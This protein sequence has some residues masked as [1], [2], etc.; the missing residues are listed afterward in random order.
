MTWD[1]VAHAI[2]VMFLVAG[3]AGAPLEPGRIALSGACALG[4]GF[5]LRNRHAFMKATAL[6]A[7]IG[8]ASYFQHSTLPALWR[9]LAMCAF[10]IIAF[11]PANR[12]RVDA[13]LA[14]AAVAGSLLLFFA[15][16]D[17]I[18]RNNW[19]VRLVPQLA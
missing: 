18:R 19:R 3:I 9:Y 5:L 16:M 14:F 12:P 11:V 7:I 15:L 13:A 17:A 8:V 4:A 6:L 10:A 1:I 2:G